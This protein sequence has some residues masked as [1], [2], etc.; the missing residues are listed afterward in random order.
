M[1][2]INI[3]I[4][5]TVWPSTSKYFKTTKKQKKK[6]IYLQVLT[7]SIVPTHCPVVQLDSTTTQLNVDCMCVWGLLYRPVLPSAPHAASM[8]QSWTGKPAT[9]VWS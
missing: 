1:L 8:F 4:Y 9:V 7:L 2:S 6:Q 3:C 5:H